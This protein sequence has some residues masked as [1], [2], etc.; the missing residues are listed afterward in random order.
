MGQPWDWETF[1]CIIQSRSDGKVKE[2]YNNILYITALP[3]KKL[4]ETETKFCLTNKSKKFT[5]K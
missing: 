1:N 4:K 3:G 5:K 2:L